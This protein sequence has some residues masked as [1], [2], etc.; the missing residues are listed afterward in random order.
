[1][2]NME[3]RIAARRRGVFLWRVAAELGYSESGFSRKLRRELPEDERREVLAII[4][5][6]AAE[7]I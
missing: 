4:D 3:I 7:A 2:E 6:L 5:R 1:M